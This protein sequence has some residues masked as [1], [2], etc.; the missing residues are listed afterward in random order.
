MKMPIIA[1][2][3]DDLFVVESLTDL[4]RSIGYTAVGFKSAE[5]FLEHSNPTQLSCLI[6][7]LKLGGMSGLQLLKKL[8]SMNCTLPCIVISSF[9]DDYLKE[10]CLSA[11]AIGYLQKPV[12]E[13]DLLALLNRALG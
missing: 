8:Q 5:D 4:L 10:Q 13:A 11:G 2:V 7:D 1:C 12:Y 6:T 3:D 9:G